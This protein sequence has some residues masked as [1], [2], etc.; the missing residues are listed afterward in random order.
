MSYD[1]RRHVAA[2]IAAERAE[3]ADPKWRAS[4]NRDVALTHMREDPAGHWYLDY[5]RQYMH[6]ASLV[7]LSSLSGR[8]LLGKAC[9][10]L[11]HALETS[12]ECYGPMPEPG[13]PSGDVQPWLRP[14]LEEERPE[15]WWDK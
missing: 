10:T 2:W 7:G 1:D 13:K 15:R 12:V 11:L 3:H 14:P 8:Q 5:V 4:V 6:R 9:V